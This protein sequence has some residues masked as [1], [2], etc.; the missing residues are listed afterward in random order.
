MA[1]I[2]VRNSAKAQQSKGQKKS[3]IRP[4]YTAK[5]KKSIGSVLGRDPPFIQDSWKSVLQFSCNLADKP[6]N[7]PT[8]NLGGGH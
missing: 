8:N 5:S 6:A 3:R 7:Q 2:R 1:L 4:L